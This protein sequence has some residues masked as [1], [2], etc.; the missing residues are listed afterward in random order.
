MTVELELRATVV[1]DRDKV[2]VLQAPD[3]HRTGARRPLAAEVRPLE[4]RPGRRRHLGV[5]QVAVLRLRVRPEALRL[6]D[7][8]RHDV[9]RAHPA[10]GLFPPV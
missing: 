5:A 1:V 3:V 4:H 2:G 9:L 10:L 8:H 6:V 7:G